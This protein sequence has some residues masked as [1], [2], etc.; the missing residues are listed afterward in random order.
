MVL[1]SI[2]FVGLRYYLQVVANTYVG[3]VITLGNHYQAPHCMVVYEYKG[4]EY[5]H[6]AGHFFN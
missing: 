4:K 1:F 6:I 2:I 3:W 5:S